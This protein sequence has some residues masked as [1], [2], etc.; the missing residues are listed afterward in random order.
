MLGVVV[1]NNR[2]YPIACGEGLPSN[3]CSYVSRGNGLES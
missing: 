1:D 2:T 3:A